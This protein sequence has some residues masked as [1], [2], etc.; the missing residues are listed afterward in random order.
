[1]LRHKTGYLNLSFWSL[2]AVIYFAVLSLWAWLLR[3]TSLRLDREPGPRLLK[4]LVNLSSIGEVIYFV[5]MS[6]AAVDWMMSREPHWISTVFG[7][8]VVMAQAVTAMCFLILMV[9]LHSDDPALKPVVQADYLNDL[10]NVLLTFVILWAYMSF[11]QFLVTWLGNQ[12]GRNCLV[13]PPDRRRMAVGR[14]GADLLALSSSV[15][16]AVDAAA[17]TQT[18]PPGSH[19]RW[20]AVHASG[21]GDLLGHSHRSA[22]RSLGRASMVLCR[23]DEHPGLAGHRRHL[24]FGV[25][26][27]FERQRRSSRS[28][29]LFL[30]PR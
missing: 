18:G 1:M 12:P 30:L 26:L 13:H 21:G 23:G 9:A 24:V 14:G 17:E 22:R 5:L 4:R 19:C 7:F 2:R 28:A 29:I 6:F 27:V 11:A 20:I 8:I 10:G 25:P 3:I 15:P 16:F